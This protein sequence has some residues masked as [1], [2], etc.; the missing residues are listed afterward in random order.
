MYNGN[1]VQSGDSDSTS[2][3]CNILV[4]NTNGLSVE[5][6]WEQILSRCTGIT[7][8]SETHC[9]K[10]MQ[11]SLPYTAND[12]KILWGA[13]VHKGSRS[14]VAFLFKRSK[15]WEARLIPFL[16]QPCQKYFE[17][18]RLVVCQVF[19]KKGERSIIIYGL[20]G[21]A[22]ARWEADRKKLLEDML[23][24]ISHD[25]TMRGSVPVVI[26]GD[27]NV[28]IHESR[29]L[30]KY[31]QSQQYFDACQWGTPADKVKN[32]S[33][34]KNG[35]RIDLLLANP[36]CARLILD[37]KIRPGVLPDDHSE[38]HVEFNLPIS[39]QVRYVP[40]QPNL[41]SPVPYDSLPKG[42]QPPQVNC[43]SAVQPFLR[44]NKIDEA[45][46]TWCSL[47]ETCLH[48]IPRNSS[49][50]VS[51][52]TGL[53]RGHVRFQKQCVFP[54]Q[55]EASSLN[56]HCR[57]VAAAIG[58]TQELMRPA[59]FGEQ[60][61]RTWKNI[62][63]AMPSLPKSHVHSIKP[64]F[65][66]GLHRE[67]LPQIL[68]ILNQSLKE[69]QTADRH[70]RINSWK[71]RMKASEKYSYKWLK[72]D[73]NRPDTTMCLSD[74]TFTANT[75]TQLEAI[76]L[77]WLPIFQKF[78]NQVPDEQTFNEHFVPFMKTAPMKLSK[79]SGPLIIQTLQKVKPSAASLDGWKPESLVALS[80]WFPE[81]FDA[82]AMILEWIEVHAQWPQDICK[83]YTSL[84]PKN[85]MSNAPAPEEHRPISVLSAIYRLW[86]RIRFNDGL[87]WQELWTPSESWGCR[88]GKGA[89]LLSLQ[90]AL[91]LEQIRLS[92]D[93]KSGGVSYDF[94]K[95]F[96]I[97]PY[98]LLFKA[99]EARGAHP[100]IMAPLK[101][102]YSN[103]QRV[104]R[105]R[106]ACSAYWQASNGLLQGCPLSMLGLNALVGVILEV[107]SVSC[108]RLIARSYA[109]DISAT[110]VDE[111]PEVILHNL[112]K[113]HRIVKSFE[114]IKFGE[115][116]AKK[117]FT[118]G[119]PSLKEGKIDPAYEHR[120]AFR[121]V[122]GSFKTEGAPAT[123]AVLEQ[124][125]FGKWSDTV[126]KMRH[127]PLPWK[128]K[129]KMLL[130]SKGQATFGQ[131][132]H[133][134]SIP[135]PDLVK[136][137]SNIMRAMFNTDFYSMNTH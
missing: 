101:A 22:G 91:H 54:K 70:E 132:T 122:G 67:V 123:E 46:H 80:K 27:Y 82:L 81:I 115:I 98:Q 105:L 5:G 111:S 6:R 34:T 31:L 74:G 49:G 39:H 43:V 85:D 76:E 26:A 124:G 90:T 92:K 117:C 10:A 66:N 35:S 103:L 109:D 126:L 99:L 71:K 93:S 73:A 78:A 135:G 72:Q 51:Y 84:I 131:G 130:A 18:G 100:Q 112:S 107:S 95:C 87:E 14:G 42:Y 50:Q 88:K 45:F 12:Y 21:H 3:T 15:I 4:A 33:H 77:A 24:D 25:V 119:H 114:E 23:Q 9:T 11:K 41:H 60:S 19:F 59:V 58:R 63:K 47:A 40:V 69:L 48:K 55:H 86:A 37:Y 68:S 134:F 17:E 52:D 83:A 102:L 121:L 133:I 36:L 13:P 108:P 120:A 1:T 137:R 64:L 30:E 97:I 57:I 89:E 79:L 29:L 16:H 96:D 75:A 44:S 94:K 20:Y 118:F 104:F 65:S 2:K 113:F 32:T 28:Q 7:I 127:C 110:I 128:D 38:V 62:Q 116:S 56:V 129:A 106:G 61:H 125:R 8:L 136:I 53:G